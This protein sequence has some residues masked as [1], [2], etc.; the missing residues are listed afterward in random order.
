MYFLRLADKGYK[1]FGA[2][3]SE[4][5]AS[6]VFTEAGLSAKVTPIGN[7]SKL[8]EVQMCLSCCYDDIYRRVMEG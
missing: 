7:D 5:A 2:E 6:K 3:I 8:Y 4:Q 1:V